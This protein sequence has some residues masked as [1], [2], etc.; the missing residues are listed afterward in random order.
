MKLFHTSD[1]HLGRRRL[2]GRL[3]DQDL[4]DAFRY[5]ADQAVAEKAEVFLLAGD[6]FDRAQVEPPHLRQAQEVLTVLKEADIPVVAIEGNHDKAFIHSDRPTWVHYLADDGL[7]ILLRPGFD[8]SGAVLKPWD[9]D[10]HEGSYIDIKGV[11]FTGAGYLGASTPNKVRQIV[12]KLEN[13]IPHVLLLHAGPD[14]FVGE[15]G[16]FQQ[17]DLDL[18]EEKLRYLALG[19]IHKPMLHGKWACNP[20]SPENCHLREVGY[21]HDQEGQAVGRGYAVIEIDSALSGSLRS[22]EVKSNPRR[23]CVRLRLDCSPFEGAESL[24]SAACEKIAEAVPDQKTVIELRLVGE[25]NLNRIA[26]DV[27]TISQDIRDQAEVFAVSIDT[28]GLNIEMVPGMGALG[29]DG[30]MPREE[31]ERTAIDQVIQNKL[32]LVT[33]EGRPDY[34]ELFFSLKEGVQQKKQ[35]EVLAEQLIS[36]PLVEQ[37]LAEQRAQADQNPDETGAAE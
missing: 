14:Y 33:L 27:E 34:V 32:P 25:L 37:I 6:L 1:I 28:T 7:L 4:A 21:D 16:G 11:R 15:G 29:G 8:A 10:T 36:S 22:L 17:A 18:L 20:G 23:R 2:D 26:L 35:P 12:D 3:P 19:H 13:D 24:M 30:M 31:L 5:I 9:P